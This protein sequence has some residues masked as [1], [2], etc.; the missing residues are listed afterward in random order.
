MRLKIEDLGIRRE[1]FPVRFKHFREQIKGWT[2]E[3]MARELGV[4]SRT[5]SYWERG[6]WIPRT[7][8]MIKQL[9]NLRI[10]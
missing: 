3:R 9:V 10:I 6:K 5:I 7:D 4:T 1:E 8:N 2:Q